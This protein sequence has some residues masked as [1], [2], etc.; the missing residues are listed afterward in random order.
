MQTNGSPD[1]QSRIQTLTGSLIKTFFPQKVAF[2]AACETSRACTV[3]ML[4]FKGYVLRW[5]AVV[6]QVAPFTK[7]TIIPVITESASAAVKQC[8]GGSTGRRC[9]FYWSGG[10][11]LEPSSSGAGE[12]MNVLSAVSSLLITEAKAPATASTSTLSG[13]GSSTGNTP[14]S[15]TTP[16]SAHRTGLNIFAVLTAVGVWGWMF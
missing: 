8:T 1:W 6:T 9:G 4:S 12:Q 15:T 16:S 11:Y 3:D 10:G 5:L 2:E 14:P 7:D 13:P